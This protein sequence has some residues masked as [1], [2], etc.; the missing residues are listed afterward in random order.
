MKEGIAN[1]KI[2]KNR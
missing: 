1:E 2:I